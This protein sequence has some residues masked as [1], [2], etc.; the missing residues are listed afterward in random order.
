MLRRIVAPQKPAI[1]AQSLKTLLF[2][3]MTMKS[4]L[5]KFLCSGLLLA[6]D[7]LG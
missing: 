6:V 5:K 7:A 2:L 1:L 3:L 4:L